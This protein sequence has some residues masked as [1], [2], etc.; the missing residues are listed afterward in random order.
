MTNKVNGAAPNTFVFTFEQSI[1][2]KWYLLLCKLPLTWF[3]SSYNNGKFWKF[4]WKDPIKKSQGNKSIPLVPNKVNG[5]APNT[6]V[7]TFEQSI[8][9]KWYLLRHSLRVG[10][11][12]LFSTQWGRRFLASDEWFLYL[13]LSSSTISD[14]YPFIRNIIW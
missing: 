13:A 9:N 12:K 10:R 1:R 14:T 7:F 8:R 2:N 5:A 6:F 4:S 11:G 3:W